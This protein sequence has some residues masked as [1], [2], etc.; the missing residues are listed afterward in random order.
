M[1]LIFHHSFL[2]MFI[3][4]GLNNNLHQQMIAI[5]AIIIF[6]KVNKANIN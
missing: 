4:A 2:K 5:G 6:G 3:S 1:L